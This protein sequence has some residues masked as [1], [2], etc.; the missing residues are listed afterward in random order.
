M[1]KGKKNWTNGTNGN[2]KNWTKA[3]FY[4]AISTYHKTKLTYAARIDLKSAS[5]NF[6]PGNSEVLVISDI[7]GST[8][9]WKKYQDLFLSYKLTAIKIT[10]TPCPPIPLAAVATTQT[11]QF[12]I[13]KWSFVSMPIIALINLQEAT[14]YRDLA[15]SNKHLCLNPW[16]T[17]SAYWSLLGGAHNWDTT[18]APH[19]QN[20]RLATNVHGLPTD[21]ELMWNVDV[22]MYVIFKITI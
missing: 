6:L 10:C 13:N 4:K 22:D 18:N 21:G 17:K 1:V 20:F 15:E 5:C 12:P 2:K 7:L 14:N 19:E 8:P 3:K 16:E 9:D 11:G